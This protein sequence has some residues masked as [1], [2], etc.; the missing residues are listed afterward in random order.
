MTTRTI[1]A[2]RT[3]FLIR[4]LLVALSSRLW[5]KATRRMPRSAPRDSNRMIEK[6]GHFPV[7][8]SRLCQPAK[9][10]WRARYLDWRMRCLVSNGFPE[11]GLRGAHHF[12]TVRRTEHRRGPRGRYPAARL[13]LTERLVTDDRP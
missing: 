9:T 5:K 2:R 12:S 10:Q 6:R 4:H 3:L 13:S 11:K 7:N 8:R 1:I